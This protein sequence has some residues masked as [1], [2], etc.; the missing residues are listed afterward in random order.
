LSR[1]KKRKAILNPN[2]K[3]IIL[4]EALVAGDTISEPNEAIKEIEAVEEVIEV[5]G[6]EED[7]GSNSEA[8]ELLVIRTRAGRAVKRPR[9]Y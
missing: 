3:F 4:A 6:V 8:E 5:G 1:G 9:E 7:E 2:R